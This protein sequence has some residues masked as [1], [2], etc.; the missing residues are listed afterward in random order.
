ME[1]QLYYISYMAVAYT[2][3]ATTYTFTGV[4]SFFVTFCLYLSALFRTIQYDIKKALS[5]LPRGDFSV[6]SR[7][8]KEAYKKRLIKIIEN[9]NDV[10]EVS[11]QYSSLFAFIVLGHFVSAALVLCLSIMVLMLV[12][13]KT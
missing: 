2:G 8:Q 1:T 11:Q 13:I 6:L 9:H 3:W 10:I 4:D 7:Q 5:D 12:G